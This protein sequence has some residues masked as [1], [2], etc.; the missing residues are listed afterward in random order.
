MANA[1]AIAATINLN[2]GWVVTEMQS[3]LIAATLGV[4]SAMG[5]GVRPTIISSSV[6]AQCGSMT[7]SRC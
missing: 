2:A 4:G 5:Q 3:S 7:R 6:A 1:Y